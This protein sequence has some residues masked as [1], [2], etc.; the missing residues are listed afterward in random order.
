MKSTKNQ[1]PSGVPQS[2]STRF[3]LSV[4]FFV[5]FALAGG[6][7]PQTGMF[8]REIHTSS[9]SGDLVLTLD[10][11]SDGVTYRLAKGPRKLIAATPIALTLD[12]VRQPATAEV[13]EV[14][15]TEVDRIIEPVAPTRRSV[16]EEHFRET[17]VEFA[18]PVAL[19]VRVYEDGAAFRWESRFGRDEITVNSETMGYHF[20]EDY[21]IFFPQPVAGSDFF[22]HQEN[23]FADVRVSETEALRSGSVPALVDLG[24]GLHLL[25]TDVDVE[26]YPGMWIV[27]G[28][29]TRIDAVFPRY[30]A[31]TALEGDRNLNVVKYDDFLVRSDGTRTYPWRA[32]LVTDAAG[33]LESTTLYSLAEPSRIEDTGWIQPGKVAWDWWND[34]NLGDV[35]FEPGVNQRTYQH[36]IDFAA[37]NELDYVILD[38]GWSV[39][40]PDNLL[41]VVPEIRM[42]ELIEYAASKDI[43]VI[44]WMTSVALERS[45]D[46]AFEQF[47]EWGVK[48][49]KVDFMQRDDAAMMAFCQRVAKVAADHRLLVDFHGG[50]KPTGLHRTYPN[51][52]THESVVGLEHNKWGR[53]ASPEMA[54]LLP[55]TR[56]AVGPMDYTPGAMDNNTFEAFEVDFSNPGSQGTRAHQLAQFVV[57]T[58]PLQ[59][60]ADTPTKYRRNPEVMPFLREVP[61]TWD[62]TVALEAKV[63]EHLALARRKGERWFLGSMTNW[64][65]RDLTLKLD[66]LGEKTYSMRYWTDGPNAA[67]EATDFSRGETRVDA[68]SILRLRLAPGGGYVAILEPIKGE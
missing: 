38:E 68:A 13:G 28:G 56:M 45:F 51:V 12:G 32:L 54:V 55:F 46:E 49:I 34:W 25:L 4:F 36:Y 2:R 23:K 58:S 19:R 59:M 53:D 1:N 33:L 64:T 35:D 61:A 41:K 66:F 39:P 9:P 62:E 57:F 26:D 52:L 21:R 15:R 20:A 43:G 40:G 29:G 11:G 44:L 8:A 47:R 60:L 18:S 50:S 37:E 14:T 6:L 5:L 42:R 16:V 67:N 63:G 17:L 22:T 31:K 48:G 3:T 10:C 65:P 27:G 7:W 24:E 30:P